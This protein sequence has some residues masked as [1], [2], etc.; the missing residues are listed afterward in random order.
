M[1]TTR[2]PRKGSLG[3]WPRVRTK[4]ETPRV[5]TWANR[6][7]EDINLLGFAGYKA[8]MTTIF[9]T[10]TR[11]HMKRQGEKRP[12]PAT[13]IECPPMRIVSV[14]FYGPLSNVPASSSRFKS[15][16]P[17]V[18]SSSGVRVAAEIFAAN[19]PHLQRT[20]NKHKKVTPDKAKAELKKINERLAEFTSIRLL[21]QTQ[22]SLTG[23]GKKKPELMEIGLSGTLEE[24]F[25]FAE[26]ALGKEFTLADVFQPGMQVDIKAVTKGKGFQG[27]TKRFGTKIRTRKSEKNKR[28]AGNVGAW[29]PA[30]VLYR[31][32]Q[33]G[34]MGYHARTEYNKL[35]LHIG[36]DPEEVN[37]DGGF[38]HYGVIKNPYLILKG[39][40]AGPTKRLIRF[41]V[42]VRPNRM[43]TSEPAEIRKISK[44]S[45]QGN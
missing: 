3:V 25:G 35:I 20:L 19:S 30:K 4:K 23:I 10:D 27:T 45:P 18:A 17:I 14:R 22:P 8:G 37:L 1:P 13:I 43:F 39:S 41:N 31:A 9:V 21:M 26:Q 12:I 32:P 5:R 6:N 16:V 7:R 36:T 33:P 29:H 38:L 11:K 15:S 28:G 2:R 40:V 44:A 34:K 24:Q 42:A